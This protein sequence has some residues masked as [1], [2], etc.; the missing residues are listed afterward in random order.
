MNRTHYLKEH[1]MRNNAYH[2]LSTINNPREGF[3]RAIETFIN[4]SEGSDWSLQNLTTTVGI[5][6]RRTGRWLLPPPAPLSVCMKNSSIRHRRFTRRLESMS[7]IYNFSNMQT[8]TRIHVV[9][10]QVFQHADAE[11]QVSGP[12]HP[13]VLQF[14]SA[15]ANEA[16]SERKLRTVDPRHC[17]W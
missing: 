12:I 7:S 8:R 5:S 1:Q 16:R 11:L 9:N 17:T 13:P 6:M 3:N 4:W 2:V 15:W 14:V 10:L